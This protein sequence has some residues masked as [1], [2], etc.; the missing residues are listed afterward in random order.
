[1]VGL[2]GKWTELSY[3]NQYHASRHLV[4]RYMGILSLIIVPPRNCLAEM[5][6]PVSEYLGTE[7]N[8]LVLF[9]C[10]LHRYHLGMPSEMSL[11]SP[12][13]SLGRMI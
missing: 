2:S 7:S 11:S 12:Y 3:Q 5:L 6:N 8:R 13:Y 9:V 4:L 1:M 10:L